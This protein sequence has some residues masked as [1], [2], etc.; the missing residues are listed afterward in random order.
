MTK[1]CARLPGLSD[2]SALRG[3]QGMIQSR[4]CAL[5]QQKDRESKKHSHYS[6]NSSRTGPSASHPAPRASFGALSWPRGAGTPRD[7]THNGY[8]DSGARDNSRGG[9]HGGDNR[10]GGNGKAH[11]HGTSIVLC[12]FRFFVS[13]FQVVLL[14]DRPIPRWAGEACCDKG[15]EC[16]ADA[17]LMLCC[18]R[19]CVTVGRGRSL[20]T[21][22]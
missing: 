3:P 8:C 21:H 17:S 19:A 9:N 11:G 7:G 5:P 2:G 20:V 4:A 10:P 18:G 6:N 13:L 14:E 22:Y 16:F 12:V 15:D 1:W